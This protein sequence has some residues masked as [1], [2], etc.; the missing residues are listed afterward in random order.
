[1]NGG[2]EDE[3]DEEGNQFDDNTQGIA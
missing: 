2:E 3:E 1:M